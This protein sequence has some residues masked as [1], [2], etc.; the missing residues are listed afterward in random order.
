MLGPWA[1]KLPCRIL[2]VM[3][4]LLFVVLALLAVALVAS[5]AQQYRYLRARRDAAADRQDLIHS[6]SVFHVVTLFAL[7]PGQDLLDGTR[8]LV[9]ASER[10]GGKTIYAG[11]VVAHGLRSVQLPEEDWDAFVLAEFPSENGYR[12]AASDPAF[13]KVRAG[14]AQSYA[15]GMKRWPSVNF[16]IPLVMLALRTAD[17]LSFQPARYPF[18][19]ATEGSSTLDRE[20]RLRIVDGLRANIGY[21]KDAV[22]VLNFLKRGSAEQRKANSG[23]GLAMFRLMAE[24]GNGPLHVG[25][26]VVLEGDADFDSVAIVYYPGVEYFAEM[27]QSD[28][29]GDI[30]GGKQLG[31]TLAAP[32]V[33]LLPHL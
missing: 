2:C 32:S 17:Y 19:P 9:E 15:M 13:Q 3:R 16:A 11:K 5:A 14:F 12:K 8:S 28:Y 7:A 31:D 20:S 21:G 22:V 29:F 26:A 33:P 18:R 1:A 27:I 30:V 24:M 4:V 6:R 10:A 23:Y 25:R